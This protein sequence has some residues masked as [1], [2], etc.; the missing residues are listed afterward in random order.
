MNKRATDRADNN[1]R[2]H[3]YVVS[4]PSGAGKTSLTHALIDRL[5]ARGHKV[6]FS[7]SCTTRAPRPGE[8]DGVD[9]HF[10]SPETFRDMIA[11]DDFLEYARVFDRYYGTARGETE[12]WLAS[13]Y[14]VILDIDWQG[15][16]QV[17]RQAPDAVL[18]FIQPPSLAELARRLRARGSEDEASVARRLDEAEAEIAHASEF[19]YR[20]VNKVF[21]NALDEMDAIFHRHAT[22][23]GDRNAL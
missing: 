14:D 18:I 5:A 15:A 1:N 3:V 10:V 20:L 9:Y 17:R 7:V 8:R 19:D 23:H 22:G 6:R 12:H 2:G 16:Q 11:D 13:G 4:A 21:D